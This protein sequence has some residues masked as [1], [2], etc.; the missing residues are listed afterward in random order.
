MAQRTK[1]TKPKT[2]DGR[3]YGPMVMT[4]CGL[5]MLA[6]AVGVAVWRVTDINALSDREVRGGENKPWF[7]DVWGE[8]GIDFVLVTGSAMVPPYGAAGSETV[9]TQ[10]KVKD[11]TLY[12]PEIMIGGVCLLDYDRDGNLDAYFV[13]GGRIVDPS[14]RNVGNR[15]Y[16]NLGG[17][18]FV[19]VTDQAGVGDPGFAMGCTTGDFNNDGF[20]DIYVTNAGP[21]V[22]LRNNGDGSFTD[23]TG[24]AMVGDA[25]FS[26]SAAFAD[27]DADGD[28]DLYVVNY[29]VWSLDTEI[30]CGTATDGLGYCDP[31]SYDAPA[32][33]TLYRNNGDGT[34]TDVSAE[35]GIRAAFGNGL[36][37]V[38]ADFNGDRRID[39][40]IA[41]DQT[42]NQLW[43]NQG[44][45]TF[46][47]QAIE[48]GVAYN[49]HGQ[50]EAGMGIDAQDVNGDGHFEIVMTH[51]GEET[52]T[53]YSFDQGFFEDRTAASGL[54]A[55]RPFTGFGTALT[56]FDNDGLLDMYVANGR[57]ALLQSAYYTVERPFS[58]PNQLFRG[59]PVGRF[60]EVWPRGGEEKTRIDSSR[61]A[62]FGDF[63]N[64][65]DIDIMVANQDAPAYV[66]EN[67]VGNHAHWVV[68][69]VLNEHGGP[70][71]GGRVTISVDGRVRSRDVRVAYS[72]CS[73]HD[74]RVHFGLGDV[75]KLDG[76][77]VTYPDGHEQR[78]GPLVADQIVTVRREPE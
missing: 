6:L 30:A 32:P 15:L 1:Q 64:D 26:S 53:L 46:F 55:S 36:G 70:A 75:T 28:Y 33:D 10:S 41:N 34:F 61:G 5:V 66:L 50:A 38:P 65:G 7:R 31:N 29:V 47:D 24:E 11:P 60:E 51:F 20:T 69:E 18:R 2:S 16:R 68:F 3:G 27:Y 59:T 23:V 14:E 73:S 12:F 57:V 62:A 74:P 77:L 19:D 44:D 8:S 22:L 17:G 39:F 9:G 35:A 37:I 40:C 78:L 71:L 56:D 54:S 76:V 21:N 63:D 43:I 48:L 25:G 67:L 72:Y 58:E 49:E 13:Q 4:V 42:A 45:G 52:N